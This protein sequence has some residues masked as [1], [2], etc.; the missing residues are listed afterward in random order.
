[1]TFPSFLPPNAT[2]LELDLEGSMA[3]WLDTELLSTIWSPDNCPS[4]FIPWLA[5]A[6]SIDVWDAEWL[7]ERKREMLRRSIETPFY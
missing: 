2:Q 5:W 3:Q 4:D 1:M 6:L 7:E